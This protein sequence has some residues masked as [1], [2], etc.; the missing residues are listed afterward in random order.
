MQADDDVQKGIESTLE[1][2]RVAIPSAHI[3]G[4][5]DSRT[6][7]S[8]KG[9][10]NK[11]T[12]TSLSWEAQLNVIAGKLA[13]IARGQLSQQDKHQFTPLPAGKVYLYIDDK[14]SSCNN[15]KEVIKATT[16]LKLQDNLKGKFDWKP[17]TFKM[18]EWTHF[19]QLLKSQDF[20]T[21]RF[22]VRYVNKHLP[23][24]AEPYIVSPH[25]HCLFCITVEEKNIHFFQCKGN[26]EPW[27]NVSY[28]LETIYNH[29]HIDPI[30]CILITQQ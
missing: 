6:H 2:L 29:H 16:L 24:N 26:H 19:E 27:T 14:A 17:S 20:Y 7:L 18:I 13:N 21:Q 25:S 1:E 9:L 23:N 5:Q 10:L 8:L 12:K 3:P 4:H 15:A 30:L 11:H 22:V 28:M